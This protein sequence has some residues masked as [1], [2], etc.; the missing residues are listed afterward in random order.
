MPTPAPAPL[1]AAL[2]G[3]DASEIGRLLAGDHDDPHRILGAHPCAARVS[4][5]G[6]P[7]ATPGGV[8]VAGG[9]IVR[10]MHP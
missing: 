1:P 6:A 8:G 4:V 9:V 2:A 10:A 5:T 7:P 3:L